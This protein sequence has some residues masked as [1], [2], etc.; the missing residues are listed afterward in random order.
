MKAVL[1]FV[2]LKGG[3]PFDKV[4]VGSFWPSH[5]EPL[6]MADIHK[7]WHYEPRG[8]AEQVARDTF[9][10]SFYTLGMRSADVLQLRWED[11]KADRITFEQSKKRRSG[12]GR[13][14]IP[15]NDYSRAI[16]ARYDKSTKTVFNLVTMFGGS[17]EALDE[18][19]SVQS[20]IWRALQ[21][22][23]AD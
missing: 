16:L 9:L 15:L 12:K 11:I 3:N 8:R 7:L 19:D 1:N 13:L 2:D 21:H 6:D 20:Q 10:F 22:Y 23:K 18:R 17:R 5:E 14:S 4:V